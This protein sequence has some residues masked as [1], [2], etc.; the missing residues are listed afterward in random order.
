[1]MHGGDTNL[2]LSYIYIFLTAIGEEEGKKQVSDLLLISPAA[3]ATF[4]ASLIFKNDLFSSH[5]NVLVKIL[6]I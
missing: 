1:M 3:D 2:F 6:P 5:G 4:N